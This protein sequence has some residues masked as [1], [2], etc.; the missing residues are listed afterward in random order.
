MSEMFECEGGESCA[1]VRLESIEP[2]V[3]S[4]DPNPAVTVF[5]ERQEVVAAQTFGIL[6]RGAIMVEPGFFARLSAGDQ[7]VQSS[8]IGG[9][10]E[11]AR[12]ILEYVKNLI[13]AD[14]ARIFR[15]ALIPDESLLLPVKAAQGWGGRERGDGR[16]VGKERREGSTGNAIGRVGSMEIGEKARA[17]T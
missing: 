6:W 8:T 14:T 12:A 10:P 1:L 13:I 3:P 11:P 9:D 17:V 4:A 2:A 16:G 5:A 7:P 15:V